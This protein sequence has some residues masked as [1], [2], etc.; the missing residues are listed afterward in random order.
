VTTVLRRTLLLLAL[1]VW[2]GGFMFYGAVVVPVGAE[3]LGSHREQGF[4]TQSVTN[5]LNV[6]GAVA[7]VLWGWE[8]AARNG[9][10]SGRRRRGVGWAVLV[11]LLGVLAWLHLRLDRLLVADDFHIID[12]LAFRRLHQWYLILSTIQWLGAVVL[13][14]W[15]IQA[16]RDEDAACPTRR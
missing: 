9:V 2:Q 1:M 12:G 8:E 10:V 5:Y 16:W 4:V 13:T 6:A 3:V 15:T 7:L 11:V 14:G